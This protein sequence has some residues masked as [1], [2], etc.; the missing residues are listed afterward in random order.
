MVFKTKPKNSPTFPL[1]AYNISFFASDPNSQFKLK[2]PLFHFNPSCLAKSSRSSKDRSV[3]RL[4]KAEPVMKA[5]RAKTA[6]VRACVCTM[7]Y[8]N[9][10]KQSIGKTITKL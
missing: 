7:Y 5:N 1:R 2:S 10:D 4:S 3:D 6:N 9:K 8:S